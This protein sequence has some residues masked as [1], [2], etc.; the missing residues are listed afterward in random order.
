MA[1]Y[2]EIIDNEIEKAENYEQWKA[3]AIRSDEI[4]GLD[5]WKNSATFRATERAADSWG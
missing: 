3:A 1:R 2:N 4:T 5:Y